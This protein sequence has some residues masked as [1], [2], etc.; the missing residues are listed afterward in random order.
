MYKNKN[1][2]NLVIRIVLDI[3]EGPNLSDISWL[4]YTIILCIIKKKL[5][6]CLC[7]QWRLW[8]CTAQPC[9]FVSIC[10]GQ[11]VRLTRY[12]QCFFPKKAWYSFFQLRRDERLGVPSKPRVELATCSV[13]DRRADHYT[14]VLHR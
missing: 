3:Q 8:I 9:L 12:R 5:N 7:N 4:L 2:F 14:T 13:T 10:A 1:S 6:L 11:V